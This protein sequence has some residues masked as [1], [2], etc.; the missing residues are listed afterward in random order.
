MRRAWLVAAACL[1]GSG[2]GYISFQKPPTDDELRLKAEV[3]GY[4]DEVA[5]AFATANPDA[6]TSLFASSI[7]HPKTQDQ[8]RDW[9]KTFFKENGPARFHVRKLEFDEI[10]FVRASLRISY[11]VETK[12]GRGDFGGIEQD[13]LIQH[14]GHWF[15]ASWE[16]V[17]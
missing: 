4:Y 13:E 6:L 8:I 3:H 11:T 5:R 1:V 15:T 9:A 2:C 17:R 16:K 12:S 10:S 7:T 14:Q